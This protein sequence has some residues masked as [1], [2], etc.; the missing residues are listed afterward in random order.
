LLPNI[1]ILHV[2]VFPVLSVTDEGYTTMY[3]KRAVYTKFDIY[4]YINTFYFQIFC[5]KKKTNLCIINMI[6]SVYYFI[7]QIY[8]KNIWNKRKIILNLAEEK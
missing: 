6:F 2:F 5:L 1:F 3:Q 4:V 7:F 8:L